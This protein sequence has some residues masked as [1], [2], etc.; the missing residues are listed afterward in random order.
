[1]RQ[2]VY[3]AT[4]Y[5]SQLRVPVREYA[6]LTLA[7]RVHVR[8]YEPTIPAG[9]DHETVR[10]WPHDETG[11][12]RRVVPWGR[13][14]GEESFRDWALRF[15][16]TVEAHWSGHLFLVPRQTP[17]TRGSYGLAPIRCLLE[18]QFVARADRSHL[19][20]AIYRLHPSE[21][22]FRSSM[23]IGGYCKRAISDGTLD[24]RDIDPRPDGLHQVPAVHELGHYLGLDHVA[25]GTSTPYG[26]PGTWQNSDI[27]GA[28]M[29]LEAWHAWPWLHRLRLHEV[30][31]TPIAIYPRGVEFVRSMRPSL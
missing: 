27:M 16:R 29:R 2:H 3:R 12:S 18:L 10:D 23:R 5:D 1:M 31:A 4:P 25:A 6:T 21:S 20:L 11:S 14:S 15:K 7:I 30:S 8:P 17:G 26:A 24:H 9:Q 22:Y 28:G 13:G 19:N